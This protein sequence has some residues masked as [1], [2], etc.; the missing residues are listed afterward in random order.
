MATEDPTPS[1]T[2]VEDDC[3][4]QNELAERISQ[5]NY[6]SHFGAAIMPCSR[7]NGAGAP[8]IP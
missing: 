4:V 8:A 3:S 2:M 6:E 7:P 1:Y 5:F